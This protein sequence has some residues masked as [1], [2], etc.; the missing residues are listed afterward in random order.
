MTLTGL[1]FGLLRPQIE[2]LLK[3]QLEKLYENEKPLILSAAERS[4]QLKA[5]KAERLTI[6]RKLSQLFWGGASATILHRDINPAAL[7]GLEA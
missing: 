3:G 7:L 1:L 6:E 5:A 4:K 2:G